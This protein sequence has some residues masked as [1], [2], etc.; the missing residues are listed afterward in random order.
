MSAKL[1]SAREMD[2]EVGLH[3]HHDALHL[4]RLCVVGGWLQLD[5]L[6]TASLAALVAALGCPEVFVGLLCF[7]VCCACVP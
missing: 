3:H 2:V 1:M 5:S 6:L 4:R 7:V